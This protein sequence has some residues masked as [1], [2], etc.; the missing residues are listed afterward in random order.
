MRTQTTTVIPVGTGARLV[1]AEACDQ[2][3]ERKEN[4]TGLGFQWSAGRANSFTI[5]ACDGRMTIAGS[6][7][8]GAVDAA[9]EA[10]VR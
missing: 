2:V 5:S 10:M 4:I 1:A 9:T 3:L 6:S 7:I 8:A